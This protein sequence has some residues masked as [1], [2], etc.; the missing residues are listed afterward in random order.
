MSDPDPIIPPTKSDSAR[1]RAIS[2]RSFVWAGVAVAAAYGGY[3]FVDGQPQSADIGRPFRK[4]LQFN[5]KVWE[6]LYG[7]DRPVP[8]YAPTEISEERENGDEGLGEDFD[9]TDW[10]LKVEGVYGHKKPVELTFEEIKAMPATTMTTEFFCIEGWSLIQTWK[11]VLMRDF[12]KRFPPSTLSGEAP[13][14]EQRTADLVPY[15]GMETPDRGYYVGLDMPSAVHVQTMLC[16]E[17]NGKPLTADHG[18]PLR[19]V[20]PVKY[21]VKNIKRIGVI[22]FTKIRPEDYWAEQGYDW[23]AGL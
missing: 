3:R 1:M 12:M 15:V 7:K 17:M 21:G 20:I 9:P 4:A 22:R 10:K 2:R 6:A 14:I 16:Y 11:G 5:E 18:A 19:L 8:T 13:D 23:F